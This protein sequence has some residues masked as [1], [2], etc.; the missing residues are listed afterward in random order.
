MGISVGK[1]KK[2]RNGHV[3]RP[4]GNARQALVLEIVKTDSTFSRVDDGW[5]GKCIFCN[6]RL[7]VWSTGETAAT[8][9]HIVPISAGGTNDLLNVALACS[10]CNSEKAVHHDSEC[11]AA[12]SDVVK[13]LL[14]VRVKRYR[15]S[16]Q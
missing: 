4:H 15:E 11:D 1:K 5:S 13:K 7:H 6:S 9:E 12:T 2:M 10:R 16:L 8:V 14:D 3:S